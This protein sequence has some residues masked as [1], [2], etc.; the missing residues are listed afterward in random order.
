MGSRSTSLVDG[1]AALH[2]PERALRAFKKPKRTGSVI[3]MAVDVDLGVVAF[4]LDRELQGAVAVPK[5]PFY[6]ITHL[7]TPEDHV[8]LKRPPLGAAPPQ[9]LAALTGQLIDPT[10][11]Q[12]KYHWS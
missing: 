2:T 9:T 8:E 6:A 3:G 12:L 1:A 10:D 4:D 5:W 11:G 7:D